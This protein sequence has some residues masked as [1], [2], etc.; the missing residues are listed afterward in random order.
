MKHIMFNQVLVTAVAAPL[1]AAPAMAGPYVYTE[2]ESGWTGSE[3]DGSAVITRLGYD[4]EVGD[5][6]EVYIE[7]GP[8]VL[9]EDGGSADTRLAVEVG[10]E[11]ALTEEV[12][13]YGEVEMLTGNLNEY[14]T[15]VGAIY[16]F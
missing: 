6:A 8:T 13:V 9:I 1:L 3:Y 11:V 10:G 16:R 7:V 4:A 14:G 12:A 15:K 5:S 2:I